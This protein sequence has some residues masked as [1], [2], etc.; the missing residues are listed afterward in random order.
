MMTA[1]VDSW[2]KK[3]EGVAHEESELSSGMLYSTGLVAGGSIGDVLIAFL[4][5]F[6]DRVLHMEDPTLLA[7][8]DIGSKLFPAL[9]DGP[10]SG[11]VICGIVF[12]ILCVLLVRNARKTLET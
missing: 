5:F 9:R 4:A 7:K 8:L 11:N 2:R 10:I 3:M 6:G 1:L 12:A